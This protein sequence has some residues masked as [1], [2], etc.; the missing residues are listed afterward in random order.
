M[1]S[2]ATS[3]DQ[4]EKNKDHSSR[5]LIPM[6]RLLPNL[7]S[8]VVTERGVRRATHGNTINSEHFKIIPENTPAGPL[9]DRVKLYDD[10][11]NLLAIAERIATGILH[12]RIVLV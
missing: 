6:A 7:P 1:L 5:H 4:L 12:P 9:R 3:I 10:S 8:V 2:E 11:G